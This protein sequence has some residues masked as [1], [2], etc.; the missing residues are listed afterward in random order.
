MRCTRRVP[1]QLTESLLPHNE[2]DFSTSVPPILRVWTGLKM[3]AL[4][5]IPKTT[6]ALVVRKA[7][8]TGKHVLH[9]A[10]LEEE[11]PIPQLKSGQVLVRVH[12]AGFNHRDVSLCA[13]PHMCCKLSY[14]RTCARY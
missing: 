3:S 10:V 8:E 11:R 1:A 5:Q 9:D 4:V 13:P 14:M 7:K 2:S 6:R 12:A